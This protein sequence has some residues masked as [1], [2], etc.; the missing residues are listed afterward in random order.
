MKMGEVVIVADDDGD[1]EVRA[2]VSQSH[3]TAT[4]DTEEFFL[5]I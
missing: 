5:R 3:V 1:D 2:S 4:L